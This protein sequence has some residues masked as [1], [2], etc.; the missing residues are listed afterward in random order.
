MIINTT[1]IYKMYTE[2]LFVAGE[3]EKKINTAREEFR[4]IATRGSIL[5]FIICDM[6]NVNCMYQTSLNQFLELFDNSMDRSEKTPHTLKRIAFIID[7]LTY[8]VY[9]FSSR[10]FYE[11]HKFLFVLLMALK[12]DLNKGVIK[13]FEFQVLIKGGAALDLNAV[14]P[15]PASW[16]ADS[17]WLNLVELANSIPKFGNICRSVQ[18]SDRTWKLWFDRDKPEEENIPGGMR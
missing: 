16:V 6:A 5:Y 4:P 8:E 9:R 15:N 10:G 18:R 11:P 3:M 13:H 14:M 1:C 7:Y 2:K 12:I 17:T